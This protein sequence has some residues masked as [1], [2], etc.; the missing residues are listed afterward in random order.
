MSLLFHPNALKGL[1]KSDAGRIKA[2]IEWLWS[3]RSTIDHAPLTGN[4]AGF[5]K[6]RVAGYR[7]IYTFDRASDDMVVHKVGLRDAIYKL[8]H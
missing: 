5:Y 7:I 3:N 6:R 2:K 4:L 1:P 8:T